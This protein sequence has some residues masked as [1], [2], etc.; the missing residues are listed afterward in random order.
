[1]EDS[2]RGSCRLYRYGPGPDRFRFEP[3][4][5][6]PVSPPSAAPPAAQEAGPPELPAEKAWDDGLSLSGEWPLFGNNL[7][8]TRI[9][10]DTRLTPDSI[11]RPQLVYDQV[12]PDS[13]GG[14]E[15]YPL[16]DG[17]I[18]YVTTGEAHVIA[19]D[20]ATGKTVWTHK[21]E[22]HV[23][24]GI[25]K[26]NRGAALW[27][28]RVYVLTPDNQLIALRKADGS[29]VFKVTVADQNKGYFESMAP[30]PRTG[31]CSSA[32]P[33]GIRA[34]AD[35][36]RRS[37]R[38]TGRSCGAFTRF[39]SGGRTGRRRMERM[40]AGLSGRRRRMIRC[41]GG[42]ISARAIRR[43][44]SSGKPARG[45]IRIRIPLLP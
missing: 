38:R 23:N 15:A 5:P 17:G 45:R 2:R 44:I 9:S 27:R 3:G 39:R 40:G 6:Q 32:T 21:P 30:W 22:I 16:I 12:L 36:W 41:I 28:D 37:T 29:E 10:P 1:M 11:G 35:L 7:Q 14:N 4:A 43:R 31:R 24:R 33:A 19:L 18:L 20:A 25:P 34:F 26:I 13:K 42:C 8:Q